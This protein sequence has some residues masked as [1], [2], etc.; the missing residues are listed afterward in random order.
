MQDVWIVTLEGR[1][2]D[3]YNY[4]WTVRF[5]THFNNM[6]LRTGDVGCGLTTVCFQLL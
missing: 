1:E 3:C 2:P 4:A 6:F 5:F